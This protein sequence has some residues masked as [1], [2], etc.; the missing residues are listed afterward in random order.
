V[1]NLQLFRV[2]VTQEWTTK[3]DAL[4]WAS[5]EESAAKLAKKSVDLDKEES[6]LSLRWAFA[7]PEPMDPD[8][9]D[10]INDDELWLIMPDG[11]IC[12][13]DRA[14]LARFQ[15]LL[16]PD[17]LEALRLARIEAGNGQLKLLEVQP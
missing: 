7:K 11:D 5:D 15:A 13:N 10:H 1:S 12:S 3:A 6:S 4:V 2:T 9:T 16:D 8:V 17:R 14:G